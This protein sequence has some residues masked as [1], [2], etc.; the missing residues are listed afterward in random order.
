MFWQVCARV[1]LIRCSMICS[2]MM[3]WQP[4]DLHRKERDMPQTFWGK[5]SRPVPRPA[6]PMGPSRGIEFL[7]LTCE[8]PEVRYLDVP[9]LPRRSSIG[10]HELG[11]FLQS[12]PIPRGGFT[13]REWMLRWLDGTPIQISGLSNPQDFDDEILDGPDGAAIRRHEHHVNHFDHQYQ[14]DPMDEVAVAIISSG[15]TILFAMA[16][17]ALAM[18]LFRELLRPRNDRSA[19]LVQVDI[20]GVQPFRPFAGQAYH[21]QADLN[22]PPSP[23]Q[24]A[25]RDEKSGKELAQNSSTSPTSPISANEALPSDTLPEMSAHG[26]ALLWHPQYWR[27]KSAMRLWVLSSWSSLE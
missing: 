11:S 9:H 1:S 2:M 21:L 5:A 10:K 14:E 18:R 23:R 27:A 6:A 22:K 12:I 13:T 4:F 3:W 26:T 8:A 19:E 16:G 7:G 20:P 24:Q 17:A 25:T 15:T